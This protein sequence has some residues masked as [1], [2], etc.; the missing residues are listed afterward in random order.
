MERYYRTHQHWA[1]RL[2]RQA[3]II[4][5]LALLAVG[6]AVLVAG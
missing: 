5:P 2:A 6:V 3:I 1:V 4:V